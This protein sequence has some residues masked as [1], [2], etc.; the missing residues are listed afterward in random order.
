MFQRKDND[1]LLA[2]SDI[3]LMSRQFCAPIMLSHFVLFFLSFSDLLVD[4][5]GVLASYS[6]TVKELK[7]LFSMLRGDGGMWVSLLAPQTL[8]PFTP[9][10]CR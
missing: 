9:T 5:L 3:I 6:I 7:L 8:D 1:W 4:M 10:G 2:P